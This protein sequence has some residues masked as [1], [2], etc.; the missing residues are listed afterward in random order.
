MPFVAPDLTPALPEIFMLVMVCAVLV[1]DVFL[2]QHQ[3]HITYML[4]QATLLGALIIT[5]T[6]ANYTENPIIA[7]HGHYIKDAMSDLLKIGIYIFSLAIFIYSRDY[8]KQ[9]NILKGEY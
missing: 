7:F 5:L 4:T 8:L 9:R 2:E 1:I 6:T 3:R